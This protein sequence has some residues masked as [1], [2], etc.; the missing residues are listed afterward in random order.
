MDRQSDNASAGH[1]PHFY[2]MGGYEGG[3]MKMKIWD[4]VDDEDDARDF[5]IEGRDDDD[6]EMNDY[7]GDDDD[8]D[9]TDDD[10][11]GD[12]FEGNN[13]LHAMSGMLDRCIENIL[14]PSNRRTKQS[15]TGKVS[16]SLN[17][18]TKRIRI[19]KQKKV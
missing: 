1:E 2:V 9:D 16:F 15:T 8:P 7:D 19:L 10:D 13:D 18:Q 4:E 12:E 11:D 5:A 14:E 3:M 17:D 6:V